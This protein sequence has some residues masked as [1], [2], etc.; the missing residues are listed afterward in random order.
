MLHGASDDT[1]PRAR[2]GVSPP[3]ELTRRR[4]LFA[5]LE[6]VYQVRFEGRGTG[7]W[8]DLDALLLVG[9]DDA[10]GVTEQM[11]TLLACGPEARRADVGTVALAT[12]S[13]LPRPLR[14][15]RLTDWWTTA[16]DSE[17]PSLAGSALATVDG[18]AAWIAAG[19]SRWVVASLPDELADREALRN[20]L[21]AG[22]FLAL[23]ALVHF[24]AELTAASRWE[25]P[26]LRAAFVLD[27]PNLHW[28]SYGHVQYEGLARHA[29]EYGY[30]VAIAMVPL[31]G[32]LAHPRVVRIF[33]ERAHLLSVC[34][35]GNDHDGPELGR[36]ESEASGIA[37]V[38]QALKRAESFRSRTGVV[39]EHVMVPPHEKLSEPA[40]RAL[41]ACGLDAVC[42]SRPHPWI[43]PDHRTPLWCDG[44]VGTGALAGWR[45]REIVA[46]GLPLLL[47]AGVDAP[48]DDLPLR[49]FLGQ[50]LILYGHHELLQA[51]PD[52]LTDAAA[53]VNAV[54]EVSWCSLAGIARSGVER[55][56]RGER[57]ELRLLAR[58]SS[59]DVPAGVSELVVDARALKAPSGATL[60]TV[61]RT[62]D[63]VETLKTVLGED[64][65]T[66]IVAAGEAS[67][68]DFTFDV[69]GQ[70]AL[71]GHPPRRRL[72][73]VVRR[74]ANESRDRARAV[75]PRGG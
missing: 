54:G 57:L 48:R 68:I 15:A 23:L 19:Q 38:M 33:R 21:A 49:A 50:P 60:H 51:G 56:R 35:H 70:R 12:A 52:V 29:A 69:P 26:P 32:W 25:P 61:A 39:V 66:M 40:A 47:R 31:D 22:R 10:A 46:D 16:L 30:H 14:G 3:I 59:V 24:L 75:R 36:I 27:D 17:S 5:A 73:K 64:S 42:A 4:R 20:R 71:A 65:R 53:A 55:K 1:A 44:P 28:P 34:V 11:P 37:L 6:S 72:R 7:E 18:R 58:Q 62:A 2:I 41:L 67:R 13:A 63:H 9:I 74:L 45:A 8:R 43:A